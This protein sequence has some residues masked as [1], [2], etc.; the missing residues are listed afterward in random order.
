M[1][2][3]LG[4]VHPSDGTYAPFLGE[5]ANEVPLNGATSSR[6]A[7]RRASGITSLSL[8]LSLAPVCQEF[9]YKSTGGSR[10]PL[11]CVYALL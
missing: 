2:Y 3:R 6:F 4:L 11:C 9:E 5:A 7:A 10:T 8:I 1:W